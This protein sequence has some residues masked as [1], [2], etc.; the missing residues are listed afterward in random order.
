MSSS[1]AALALAL[2][3]EAQRLDNQRLERLLT[4]LQYLNRLPAAHPRGEPPREPE[5]DPEPEP[6]PPRPER[7]PRLTPPPP[8]PPPRYG[9][10]R[11]CA[12]YGYSL[13]AAFHRWRHR[14]GRQGVMAPLAG[15]RRYWAQWQINSVARAFCG[16][17]GQCHLRAL[18][19]NARCFRALAAA[20]LIKAI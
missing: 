11:Q 5:P 13:D 3:V 17:R 2:S 20:R 9:Y 12:R 14:L 10:S 8:P 6:P 7:R 16:L 18:D 4:E 15:W 1:S 19:R